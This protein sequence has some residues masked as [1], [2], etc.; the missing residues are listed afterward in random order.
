M[1]MVRLR[2]RPRLHRGTVVRLSFRLVISNKEK[3]EKAG[4]AGIN[5]NT[6][7]KETTN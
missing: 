1:E 2:W 6:L 5:E 4:I 7:L 3:S